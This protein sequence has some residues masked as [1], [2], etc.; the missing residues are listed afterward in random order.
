MTL[1]A[2]NVV[3]VGG[4]SGIGKAVAHSVLE[5]GAQVVLVGRSQGKLE[6]ASRALG[7][8]PRV[9]IIA[10]DVGREEEVAHALA[11]VR[12]FDHLVLTAGTG[13][14]S[15][16]ISSIDLQAARASIES[17]LVASIC[18]AKHS[19]G[20]LRAGGSITFTS[21]AIKDRPGP[22]D[23][24]IA[25]VAG[26]LGYLV[27]ALALEMAPTRVNVVSP[28]VV[29]TPMWDDFMGDGKIA[30]FEQVAG[31]LPVRHIGSAAELAQAYIYL[32]ENGF[33]TG[34]TL[35]VDGGQSL[36]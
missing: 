4:S 16:E 9:R 22:G 12:S 27:R 1:S 32:M 30:L 31:Q 24:V 25:A 17:K 10:A 3:I 6:A 15:K 33:T 13:P 29:D 14:Y 7:G 8:P 26:S 20:K 28:G 21:G 23:S 5:R 35:D 18:L 36:V 19:C 2:S 11:E 34:A